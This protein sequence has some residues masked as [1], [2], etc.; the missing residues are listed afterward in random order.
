MS[1]T[2]IT[3][4]SQGPI[5]MDGHAH[6]LEESMQLVL[7]LHAACSY[8][9]LEKC[10]TLIDEGAL[11]WQQDAQTGWTALHYAAGGFRLSILSPGLADSVPTDNGSLEL[12]NYLL[13][14]GAVWNI[15]KSGAL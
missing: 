15:G 2:E 5:E 7:K 12:V 10:K 4:S 14:H 13:R 9:D 6:A 3:A 11:A 8:G 1:G